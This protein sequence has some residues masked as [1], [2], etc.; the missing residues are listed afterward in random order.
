MFLSVRVVLK[1]FKVVVNILRI[2]TFFIGVRLSL[3]APHC[4]VNSCEQSLRVCMEYDPISL[5]SK[6]R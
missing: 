3:F 5:G 2:D 1:I 6:S 4:I